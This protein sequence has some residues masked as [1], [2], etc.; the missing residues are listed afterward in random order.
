MPN[1]NAFEGVCAEAVGCNRCFPEMGVVRADVDIAQPRYVGP[2]YWASSERRLFFM[3]N[4]GAGSGSSLDQ[5]MR[6]EI[7]SYRD[8]RLNLEE[9]FLRQRERFPDWGRGKFLPFVQKLGGSLDDI[10]L[11][12]VAWCATRGDKYPVIMLETCFAAHTLRAV[13]ALRPTTIIACGKSAQKFARRAGLPFVAAPHYT[14]RFTI[15]FDAIRVGV[16]ELARTIDWTEL[17]RAIMSTSNEARN[18]KGD[19]QPGRRFRY[20]EH[21]VIPLVR[22]ANPKTGKSVKRYDC[23]RDRMTVAEYRSEVAR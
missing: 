9:L 17:F 13:R 21:D 11:L 7:I 5:T 2:N 16:V 18:K 19:R 20:S 22:R 4:P 23:Y 12:N 15:D 14:A 6:G 10:A 8:G 1:Y 3:I